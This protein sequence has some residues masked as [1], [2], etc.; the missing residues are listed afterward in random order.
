MN[1]GTLIGAAADEAGAAADEAGAAA[2]EAEG[3]K[4]Q[5]YSHLDTTHHFVPVA[6]ETLGVFGQRG[7]PQAQV[8][9]PGPVVFTLNWARVNGVLVQEISHRSKNL[10]QDPMAHIHLLQRLAIAVQRGNAAAI[11]GSMGD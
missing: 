1:E 8:I 7:K 5:K 10:T 4:L 11:L 3:R 9:S 2:D 6:I